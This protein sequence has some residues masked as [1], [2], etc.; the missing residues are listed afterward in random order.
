ME[1]N[2]ILNESISDL[3]KNNY[4][5]SLIKDNKICFTINEQLYRVRMP[6]QGEQSLTEYKKNL[7]QLEYLKQEGCIT[8]S[9]LIRQLK[10][11]NVIDIEHL[12]DL[13]ENLSKELKRFWF[14]LATKDSGDKKKISEYS[15]NITK[16]QESLQRLSLD[17]ASHLSP[18][19]E[20][21]L[22]KFY[23]EYITFICAEYHPDKEWKK[24]WDTLEDFNKA[25]TVLTNKA[26]ASMT[27]LLLNKR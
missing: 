2:E 1:N 6:N 16:I 7:A 24:V 17:I 14:L 13:K 27:W 11:N 10:L 21:R 8:R 5:D 23:V 19:L 15:E 20:S 22:E 12:E 4:D 9:Q 26:I 18:S 25:D 3:F